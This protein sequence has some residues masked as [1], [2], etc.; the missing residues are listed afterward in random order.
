MKKNHITW[1]TAVIGL[2]FV[3][4]VLFNL[5][6]HILCIKFP[7]N[8]EYREGVVAYWVKNFVNGQ[9]LYPEIQQN[10]PYVHNPYTPLYYVVTGL[11]QKLMKT[12]SIFL[13]GRLL[14][15]LCLVA[16]SML[17][18]GIVKM[19]GTT[20]S[21]LLSA[22]IFFCSPVVTNYGCL[23]IV[24][25]MALCFCLAGIYYG[26]KKTNR[27]MIFSGIFCAC[28]I[29]TKPVFVIPGLSMLFSN[30]FDKNVRRKLFP[31]AFLVTLFAVFSILFFKYR[32]NLFQH[33]L[34]FNMLPL[35]FSHFLNV[36]SQVGVRHT[37]IFSSIPLLAGII[38][39]RKNP[40]Y[41]YCIF[42]PLTL[43]FSAKIGSE[44]NYFLE[45]IAL[46][47]IAAGIIFSH[48][49]AKQII[50]VACLGQLF[51][52]LPF[53]P[54][55]VF[56]KTYGQE[57]PGAISS[58]PDKTL[59][60]VDEIISSELMGTSDPVLAEDTGW[61]VYAD[62]TV[63]LEP[64]QFSLLAKYGRWDDTTIVEMIKE[65]QFNLIIINAETYEKTGEKFTKNMLDAMKFSYAIRR[66]IGNTYILEPVISWTNE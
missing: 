63:Y 34:L 49:E 52:F 20:I 16:T 48:V 24:D 46:S 14:S 40:L 55:P 28:S 42:I 3:V 18:F 19:Y 53:K 36:F 22:G 43:L 1:L 31:F 33:L 13:A 57:I 41:W 27:S 29:L 12:K 35:N 47:S 23:E 58:E 38:K 50:A 45:I 8:L 37:F 59:M 4:I 51:L 30:F 44:S 54:A 66:I 60:E 6:H 21:G 11:T 2:I 25:M 64:Y 10:P 56:T 7:Y 65:K 32:N 9:S 15:F 26:L 39:D 61:L 17:I 62:K 5:R